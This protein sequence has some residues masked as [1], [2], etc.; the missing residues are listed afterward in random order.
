[1]LIPNQK[2]EAL[3]LVTATYITLILTFNIVEVIILSR[4]YNMD[5][6][7][8]YI[9]DT[10]GIKI[11]T[12]SWEGA[13]RLPFYLTGAYT[14]RIVTFGNVKCL[15]IKPTSEL[16]SLTSVKKHLAKLSECADMPLVLE[17]KTLNARQRR[18]LIA[19]QTPFV[20]QGNQ[21]YLPFVGAA[22]QERY[23][24]RQIRSETLSPTAQLLLFHYLYKDECEIYTNGLAELFNI[25]PMQIT[26]AAKQLAALELITIRKDG[27]R[28]VISGTEQ[29]GAL[30][31]KAKPH[32][33]RLIRRR[34]YV[35]K[36]TLPPNLPL[37]GVSAL[38]E[39]TMLNPPDL[40]T[41]AFYGRVDE[42]SGTD[43]LV[44]ADAQAEVEIWRYL[45]TLL[46]AKERL[47][48][49]LSLWTTLTDD[50]ARIEIAKDELLAGVWR[51]E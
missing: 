36:D 12:E 48:D 19:A 25:S 4:G 1:V 30:F 44:D 46:S 16:A 35:D 9:A 22:L 43:T 2:H 32:L 40:T 42:L 24:N 34:K 5:K 38:A 50:D 31:D 45:P 39:Y 11:A 41:Y 27:V 15:F 28:I 47:S 17:L 7:M 33:T 14:F 6:A 37:A 3:L 21:L 23:V 51:K 18:A 29:R 8:K 20:V 10:L 13:M 49:P 26:R